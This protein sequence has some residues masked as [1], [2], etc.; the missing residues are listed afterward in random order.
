M[1]ERNG[2]S[3]RLVAVCVG[4]PRE[5]DRNGEPA[6]TSI[7]KQAV[8][9]AVRAEGV[10]LDGDDQAD[11][12]NHGG[13]D[14]A[15]YAYSGDDVRWWESELGRALEPG[16]FGENL[17][18]D[19]LDVTGAVIGERWHVGT[20]V[21]EVSE[22]RIPCWKLNRRLD[23]A[24]MIQ[25]FRAAGRPGAYLRI[26]TEGEIEA[27]QTVM[28][29]DVPDHGL[30]VGDVAAIHRDREGAERLLA[31]DAMSQASRDWAA[32]SQAS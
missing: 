16:S 25:Q 15:V 22:P 1:S 26:I 14:K 19:G 11:R 12:H 23:E 4:Q 6:M 3:G 21:F 7:W 24:R 17:V 13:Y 20:V 10:N 8:A 29:S 5:I 2:A 31:V 27:G 28:V 32:A 30:T 9:G 18:I